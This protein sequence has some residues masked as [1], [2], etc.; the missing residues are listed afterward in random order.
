MSGQEVEFEKRLD[1]QKVA[2]AW[3]LY[4][5]TLGLLLLLSVLA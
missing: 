3:L 4:A 2:V 1:A 5:A